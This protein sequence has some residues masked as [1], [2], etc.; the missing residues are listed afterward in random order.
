MSSVPWCWDGGH[1]LP[2]FVRAK[3]AATFPMDQK[4]IAQERELPGANTDTVA[5]EGGGPLQLKLGRKECQ[6]VRGCER[7]HK[8]HP[9]SIRNA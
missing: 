8:H 3:D 4:L 5:W 6:C 1:L 7:N 9:V 2:V